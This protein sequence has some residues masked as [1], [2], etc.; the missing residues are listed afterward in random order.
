[1]H[2]EEIKKLNPRFETVE[3]RSKMSN[4]ISVRR[5]SGTILLASETIKSPSHPK[6]SSP[7]DHKDQ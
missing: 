4:N 2:T 6:T 5:L 7:T 1:M 3:D